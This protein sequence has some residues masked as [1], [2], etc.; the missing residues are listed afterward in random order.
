[1][2]ILA[3]RWR[4]WSGIDGAVQ[5]QDRGALRA[6]Q[7]GDGNGVREAAEICDETDLAGSTCASLSLGAG[8]L[9]CASDCSTFDLSGCALQPTAATGP[10][11][12]TR[13]ATARTSEG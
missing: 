7:R 5:C 13:F 1:M 11:K 2:P 8:T 10:S 6:C 3:R 12:E 9:R 4:Q